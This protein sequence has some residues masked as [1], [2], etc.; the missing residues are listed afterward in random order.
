MMTKICVSSETKTK[1]RS[2]SA[3]T[4]I[5]AAARKNGKIRSES[6]PASGESTAITAGDAISISPAV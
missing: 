2:E 1:I 4:A 3:V 6:L 5:P